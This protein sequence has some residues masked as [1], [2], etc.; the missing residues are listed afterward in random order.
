[1]N[2]ETGEI[3]INSILMI[4]SIIVC[5]CCLIPLLYSSC[6]I[7][8]FVL[9]VVWELILENRIIRT[10]R[11]LSAVFGYYIPFNLRKHVHHA[12][13]NAFA[14]TQW[15]IEYIVTLT[16]RRR[17]WRRTTNE[18]GYTWQIPKCHIYVVCAYCRWPHLC[19]HRQARSKE[20]K[21]MDKIYNI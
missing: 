14:R 4:D 13:A 19:W 8:H 2:D 1:M 17:R 7:F 15:K 20:S 21:S 11:W 3:H 9:S 16:C 18:V 10:Y 12:F 5:A 6:V